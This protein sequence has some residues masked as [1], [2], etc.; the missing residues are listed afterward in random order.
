MQ[1]YAGDITC[2][3]TDNQEF[4][5]LGCSHVGLINWWTTD[6][7][8][9]GSTPLKEA[10]AVAPFK[11]SLVAATEVGQLVRLSSPN[12]TLAEKNIRVAWDNHIEI[13]E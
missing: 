5:A 6:G 13:L 9:S 1:G 11:Q 12:I 4:F 7:I 10:C 2:M 8:W 3:E